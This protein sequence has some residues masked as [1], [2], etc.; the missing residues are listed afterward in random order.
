MWKINV[1]GDIAQAFVMGE[2]ATDYIA[3]ARGTGRKKKHEEYN[4]KGMHDKDG[5]IGNRSSSM[6][7]MTSHGAM[8]NEGKEV[9]QQSKDKEVE[10]VS[11]DDKDAPNE[12]IDN[13][14][15]LNSGNLNSLKIGQK[16]N[17]LVLK[18]PLR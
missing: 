6:K 15:Y 8:D 16:N 4:D 2:K 10:Y 18:P 3:D 14:P 1:E 9:Q 12:N 5:V 13:T 11:N 7:K 17:A